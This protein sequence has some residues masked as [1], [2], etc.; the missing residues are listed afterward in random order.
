MSKNEKFKNWTYAK[1]AAF[2]IS[3]VPTCRLHYG[4][5]PNEHRYVL[6]VENGKEKT[7]FSEA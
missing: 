1:I 5:D 4:Y 7:H 3:A 2:F 6:M